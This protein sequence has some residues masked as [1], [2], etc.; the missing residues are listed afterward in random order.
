[1][2][3]E[4][5]HGECVAFKHEGTLDPCVSLYN[6]I[7][8]NEKFGHAFVVQLDS[9]FDP[10]GLRAPNHLDF[11]YVDDVLCGLGGFASSFRFL[12]IQTVC[13]VD[14]NGLAREAF[15]LNHDATF[16]QGNIGLP[17][18]VYQMHCRQ[19]ELGVQPLI[20]A[21]IPCEPL[22]S[23]GHQRRHLDGRSITLPDVLKAA[24]FLGAVGLVLECVPEAM[25]DTETQKA[26]HEYSEIH[27]CVVVERILFLHHCWPSKR[28]RWFAL[29][30]FQSCRLVRFWVISFPFPLAHLEFCR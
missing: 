21:G 4:S 12:S 22:S 11:G 6:V 2:G 27:D 18:A 9:Q 24:H 10:L 19:H 7:K 3:F 28:T 16:I 17:T 13:A 20:S 8:T 29:M 23:Q 5:P 25:T 15:E 14:W 30:D 1:M 26:I